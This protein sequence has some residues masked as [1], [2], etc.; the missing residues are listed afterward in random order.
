[1]KLIIQAVNFDIADKLTQYI[2]K[3]TKKYERVLKENVDVEFRLTVVKP[4]S[5]LN[6]E[7]QLRVLGVGQEVFARKVCDTFEQ[8]V[9]ET[10]TAMERQMERLK[11]KN[12]G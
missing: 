3:K 8:G 11:E 9:D 7:T 12:V 1:M 6:K 5:T 4:E 2:E 10:L